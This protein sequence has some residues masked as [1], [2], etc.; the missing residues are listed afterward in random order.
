MFQVR[1]KGF[2]Q[3]YDRWIDALDAAKPL[4]AKCGWF[5][6][7]QILEKS[8][9]IWV[10]SKGYK[11][12]RFIGPGVYD[13]LAKRFVLE[14]TAVVPDGEIAVVDGLRPTVGHREAELDAREAELNA[15]EARLKAME[16]DGD[17][18]T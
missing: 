14:S 16:S 17:A 13:R 3:T 9:L 8:E 4:Q 6:E 10:Y 11:Y 12:P 1:A 2:Q 18:E 15:R 5:D 7:V